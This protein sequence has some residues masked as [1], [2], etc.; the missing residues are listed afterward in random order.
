MFT[1]RPSYLIYLFNLSINPSI[2][3]S[4]YQST[5]L[6]LSI[7]RSIYQS[8]D[9]SIHL[10]IYQSSY[11]SIYLSIYPS[12]YLSTFLSG[13][14]FQEP[15]KMASTRMDHP[16]VCRTQISLCKL[17]PQPNS[18]GSARFPQQGNMEIRCGAIKHYHQFGDKI[19]L[20]I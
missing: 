9:Q 10:P 20:V 7:Y 12:I 14:S 3:L 1:S 19:D 6:Y 16:V 13:L 8:I 2:N 11:L 4:I 5:Y 17:L 18:S 15:P